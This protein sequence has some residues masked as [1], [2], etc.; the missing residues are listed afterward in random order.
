[1]EPKTD[2]HQSREVSGALLNAALNHKVGQD[3]LPPGVA[4][5]LNHCSLPKRKGSKGENEKIWLPQCHLHIH[6]HCYRTAPNLTL[7]KLTVQ[8]E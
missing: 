3:L 7:T 5:A 8:G 4:T 2:T 1:M 6:L